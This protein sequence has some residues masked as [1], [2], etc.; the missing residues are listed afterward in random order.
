MGNDPCPSSAIDDSRVRAKHRDAP[1]KHCVKVSLVPG[2]AQYA[3][4]RNE[5]RLDPTATAACGP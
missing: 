5:A 1:K 4:P 3:E 2:N